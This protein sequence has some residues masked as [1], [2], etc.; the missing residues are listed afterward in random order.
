MKYFPLLKQKK[1]SRN[2]VMAVKLDLEKAYG[3]ISW[4]YIK[5]VLQKFGFHSHW[6]R[7]VL[8]CVSSNSFSILINLPY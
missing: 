3:L 5:L 4:D 8:E 7:L 1:G 2:G 6:I